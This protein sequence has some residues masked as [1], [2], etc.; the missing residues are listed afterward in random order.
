MESCDNES[1]SCNVTADM[2]TDE[3][4][5][6]CSSENLDEAT[7]NHQQSNGMSLTT[8]HALC[9]DTF[10]FFTFCSDC[11]ATRST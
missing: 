1:D 10:G 4:A 7:E 6:T 9:T 11:P 5:I 8:R 3:E 2:D